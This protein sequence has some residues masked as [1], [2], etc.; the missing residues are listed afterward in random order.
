MRRGTR[1]KIRLKMSEMGGGRERRQ[2]GRK[3]SEGEGT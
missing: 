2:E 1:R 3:K